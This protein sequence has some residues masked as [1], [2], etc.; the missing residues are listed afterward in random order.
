MK[1]FKT[2]G[3]AFVVRSMVQEQYRVIANSAQ[4]VA[5]LITIPSEGWVRTIRKALDMSGAQLGK[6][7]N[8]SRNRI[9]VLEKR[10][11]TGDI[12]LNQLRDL[13]EQLDCK[14][15]YALVPK[16]RINI[17]LDKRA[18][19]LATKQLNSNSQNMFLEA[20][21]IDEEQ[22]KFLIQEQKIALL[23]A[24]GREL[25]KQQIEETKN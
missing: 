10:E 14:L 25:W 15:T 2:I 1:R 4:K 5:G 24:G 22:K 3:P 23:R 16:E 17:I 20:Q 11:K 13:A 8:L 6:R 21:S 18:E 12:T 7:L 19:Y 9:S